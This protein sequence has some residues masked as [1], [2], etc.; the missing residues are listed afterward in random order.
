MLTEAKAKISSVITKV[1]IE[2]QIMNA[3]KLSFLDNSFDTVIDTFSLCVIPDPKSAIVEMA[4][5]VKPTGRVILLE[6]TRR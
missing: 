2:L 1:P 6:N 3:E 5:V 4:R